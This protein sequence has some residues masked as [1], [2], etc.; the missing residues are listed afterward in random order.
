MIRRQAGGGDPDRYSGGLSGVD[1]LDRNASPRFG[2]AA[3]AAGAD[4]LSLLGRWGVL[5]YVAPIA[6]LTAGYA[7]FRWPTIRC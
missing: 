2:L 5:G 7:S 3:A 4:S 1:V 6:P